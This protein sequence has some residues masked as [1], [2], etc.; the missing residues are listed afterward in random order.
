M[1]QPPR[2]K[3]DFERCRVKTDKENKEGV[4]RAVP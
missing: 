2:Q 3:H 4:M 1:S